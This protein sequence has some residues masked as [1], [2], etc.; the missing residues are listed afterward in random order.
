MTKAVVVSSDRIP[1]CL[2]KYTSTMIILNLGI[3]YLSGEEWGTPGELKEPFKENYCCW[4]TA[5][6]VLSK[7]LAKNKNLAGATPT[8]A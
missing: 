5:N 4:A 3:L 7:W 8:L 6:V 2:Q 1:F